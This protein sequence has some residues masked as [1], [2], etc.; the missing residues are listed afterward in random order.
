MEGGN[1]NEGKM[2]NACF[3]EFGMRGKLAGGKEESLAVL[4]TT[5]LEFANKTQIWRWFALPWWYKAM[6]GS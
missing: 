5:G 2:G 1:E 6:Q 4:V 3:P